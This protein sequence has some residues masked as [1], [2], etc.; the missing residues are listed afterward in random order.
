MDKPLPP[1]DDRNT[2]E[3]S[4]D[5]LTIIQ[6]MVSSGDILGWINQQTEVDLDVLTH[7]LAR[8]G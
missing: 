3:D 5:P 1:L 4:V 8:I 7:A 2:V 6:G